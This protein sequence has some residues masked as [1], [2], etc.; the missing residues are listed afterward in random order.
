MR[1]AL[2][3]AILAGALAW[4]AGG[5]AMLG[6]IDPALSL[7]LL[8]LPMLLLALWQRG[9]DRAN[10]LRTAGLALALL[11]VGQAAAALWLADGGPWLQLG[12]ILLAGT[13]SA[14]I[15]DR[16]VQGRAGSGLWLALAAP[17]FVIGWFV[18]GHAALG[19]LYLQRPVSAAAPPVTLM[20]GLPLRWA[21]GGDIA[22]MIAEGAADDPALARIEAAGP[23]VLVDSLADHVPP[24]GGALLLAHPRALTPRDLVAVDVFVRG[25]GRAVLLADALSGW[26]VDHPLGD[27]R[28]PP[29]T[30]LL[31]PLLDHWGITLGAAPE[32]ET[33]PL[34]VDVGGERLRLFSAGRF[35]TLPSTC[36]ALAGARISTCHIGK[37][38]AW[39]VGDA[40]LLF[41]PLW[42]PLVPGAPHLRRADTM[43]WLVERLWGDAA[44]DPVLRPL[45]I[46]ARPV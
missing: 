24:A 10:R 3:V 33:E 44:R 17:L 42:A 26:P 40:D 21:G 7:P 31:T 30:S 8:A 32:G 45:W 11:V 1:R 15:A 46:R 5:Q 38:E 29:V 43:E 2:A 16:L 12:L 23:V 9:A 27:A 14:S 18:A 39:L 13:V 37:G 22:S 35:D 36:R 28:N 34:A 4:F 41:A 6:R 19:A 20:T 25:G